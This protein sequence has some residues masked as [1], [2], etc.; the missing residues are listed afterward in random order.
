LDAGFQTVVDLTVYGLGRDVSRV[1]R[2]AERAGI[3]IIVATGIY[4]ARDL[5][6]YFRM[7]QLIDS[8]T[9]IE[10][11]LVG[12]IVDG[13][14]DTGAHAAVIK[15]ATD[16]PEVSAGVETVLRSSARAQLRTG[17]PISTHTNARRK[18]GL[19]QQRIFAEEGVELSRVII[20]HSGDTTDLGYL[21]E[22]VAAGSYVGMDRFGIDTL[23][24]FEDRVRVVA[25]LCARGLSDRI[26]LSHDANCYSDAI[27][28]DLRARSGH[29]PNHNYL[30]IVQDVLP[31]LRESG[32]TEKDITQM[33]T[34]N[35]ATIFGSR[36]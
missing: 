33:L 28:P 15:C 14:F 12:E 1:K 20:G 3:N 8:S 32:V 10:D 13:I 30:H 19:V 5:P 6:T 21:E 7:R 26:V 18:T 4:F 9:F 35:A 27:P 25:E 29:N 16:H 11:L 22:I 34:T 23:V 36:G 24:S 31:A 17:V 2:V